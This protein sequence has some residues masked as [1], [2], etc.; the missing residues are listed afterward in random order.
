MNK[1]SQKILWEI[2]DLL[3]GAAFPF[4]IQ[5]VFS[6]SVI[7][8]ADYTEEL[9]VSIVALLFG[10]ALLT[11]AYIIFG[12]QNGITAYRRTVQNEKKRTAFSPDKKAEYHTGEYAL[13]K[14]FLIGFI[15][16]LPFILIQFIECL[17]HNSVTAFL[18]RYAFGWAYYPFK[19]IGL[20]KEGGLSQWLN[21]LWVIFPVAVHAAAYVWG[22]V[23]E[24]KRQLVVAE[25]QKEKGNRKK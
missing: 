1:T 3:V 11:G 13:Y 12:R 10:E 5:L 7:L 20:S 23:K 8:F 22:G 4:M 18:L 15:S 19:L 16:T 25:A 2:K 9:A 17:A 6:A 24:R 21:F 14:G